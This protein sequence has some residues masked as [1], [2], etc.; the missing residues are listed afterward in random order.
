MTKKTIILYCF[1][2]LRFVIQYIAIG[3]EYDLDNDELLH[4]D[5]GKHLAWG[6]T[7]VPPNRDC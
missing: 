1:I 4:L 5:L 3:P 7:S 2:L 6:Y